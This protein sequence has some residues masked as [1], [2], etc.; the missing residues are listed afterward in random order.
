[1]V[2]ATPIWLWGL[3]LLPLIVVLEVWLTR[4]DRERA[5]RLVSRP[6]WP[7]VLRREAEAWRLVRTALVVTG[8]AAILL[9]LARPQWGRVR[10]KVEREGVDVVLVLDTSGSMATED[11][12]PNRFFLARTALAGL[13][14]R[15][16]G[17]RFALLAFEGEAYPLVPL[18]LDADA[19]GLF[20]ETLAPGAVPAPGTSLGA[21][22][23]RGLD[24]FVD[25]ARRNKVMVLVSDGEDLEGDIA[26]A[27]ARAKELGVVVQAVAVGTEAGQP[28]PSF[29]SQGERAGFKKDENGNVVVSRLN[30]TTLEEVARGTGG[31][32]FRITPHDT[33]LA[34]L[35]R[36]IDGMEKKS[37]AREYSYRWK[38][39]FQIPLA[40]G[41]AFVFLGLSLPWR[42]PLRWRRKGAGAAL[43]LGGLLVAGQAAA[44]DGAGLVDEILLRPKRVTATGREEFEKGSHPDALKSFDEA[45]RLRPRDPRAALNLA[46]ALYKNGRLDEAAALYRALGADLQS[47]LAPAARFNLGNTLYQ[48]KDYKGAVGAYRDALRLAPSDEDTRRNMELA[49]R[50]LKVQQEEKKRSGQGQDKE[51]KKE[52]GKQ[53]Q[54][55]QSSQQRQRPPKTPEQQEQERF[56]KETGMPKERAMQLLDALQRNEKEEQRKALAAQRAKHKGGKDW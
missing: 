31:Q 48:K 5:A 30:M 34:A 26:A 17:D 10:E 18:T 25:K 46:D 14:S 40:A 28:V 44:D 6:L 36:A 56:R 1:M 23:V 54:Q 20:L 41:L 12:P 32:V 9:A 24:L 7:R 29:D 2:F 13:V 4:R 11:V 33:T 15:L 43:I 38:E 42:V 16:G 21:G 53:G 8:T 52:D 37:L 22:L 27:V 19:V 39:R 55:K 47:G 3:V 35:A 51:Q 45:A 49:L 50:A